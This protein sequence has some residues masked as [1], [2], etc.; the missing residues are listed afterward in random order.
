Q[1]TD[2]TLYLGTGHRGRL[3]RVNKDGKSKVIWTADEPEIFAVAL[4]RKGDL[5][6]ATSPNGK[7]YRIDKGKA[8]EYFDPPDTYI[9]SLAFDRD[10]ALFVGAGDEGTV[11]RVTAAG[12]GEPYYETGQYHV[13]CL[14]F[15]ASGRL[16]AGTEPNGIL[17]RIS[18]ADKAFVLYDANLPEIRA[19]VPAADGTVYAAALGG[20]VSRRTA[21]AT[22][23]TAAATTGAVAHTSITVTA[24]QG[25]VE[26]KPPQQAKP[27]AAAPAMPVAVSPV[28]EVAGVEKSAV[29]RIHPDNTVET[30]WSSTE[31]NAYD[32]L[33][34]GGK[35]LFSTDKQGR[36][37]ELNAGNRSLT[38]LAQTNQS[39]AIRLLKP[40]RQLLIATGNMGKIFQLGERRAGGG[41]YEAPIHDAGSVARWGRLS[42]SETGCD[43][44]R[45]GFRTRAGNTA[46]PDRTWSDWSDDLTES[47]GSP[48]QSPNARYIQWSARFSGAGDR[49]PS[50]D[51]ARLAYL[52]QHNAPKVTNINISATSVPAA[53]KKAAQATAPTA[54]YSIT[55][56]DTGEAGASSVT[57]TSTQRLA[58]SRAG[59]IQIVWQAE[60]YDGDRLVYELAFRGSGERRWKNIESELE[61]TNYALDS[62][63][64]ADGRY[65]FRVR[66]SDR[67]ANPPGI[68][69][70]AELISAPVLLDQTPPTVTASAAKRSG[71]AVELDVTATD[72]ASELTRFEYSLD[73]GPW[74]PAA[75]ADGIIDSLEEQFH[76][77][78]N[79]VTPGEHLL[80]LRTH[81]SAENAGLGKVVLR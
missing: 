5:F 77:R 34:T 6:A 43:G 63:I 47:S 29:Y 36:I 46:R 16:L 41:S 75:P 2:G 53:Q 61:Q 79:N 48:I 22:A 74:V 33:D 30:L 26:V 44:C 35:L 71:T 51:S 58:R 54:A 18:A 65:F 72:A 62:D 7:V 49:A 1:A 14:A 13:T 55:V 59:Q 27:A 9:W 67:L 60:D 52:R 81:D 57:G 21:A 73:A 64:L 76:L 66:V 68:A 25:G 50:L 19:V 4:N 8:V 45:I 31:E 70:D 42:W 20:S 12:K 38:L 10:G 24:A 39:E 15:D 32:L 17:Y 37:Y 78:I 23:A 3:F 80:V 28:F 56:T 11:Y 69:R 40:G